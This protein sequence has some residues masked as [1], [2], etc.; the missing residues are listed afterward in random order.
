MAAAGRV[1]HMRSLWK[2]PGFRARQAAATRATWKDPGFRARNAAAVRARPINGRCPERCG[3]AGGHQCVGKPGHRG[4]AEF[5]A[6]CPE[7]RD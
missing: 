1:E 3:G 4:R 7:R 6:S 2:D 5:I